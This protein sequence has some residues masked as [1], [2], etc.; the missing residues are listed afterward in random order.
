MPLNKTGHK[1]AGGLHPELLLTGVV[2]YFFDKLTGN[3][4]SAKL[5]RN[6]SV[7]NVKHAI[8]LSVIYYAFFAIY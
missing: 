2:Q 1:R 7:V 3:T 8:F 6:V 5:F 4:V